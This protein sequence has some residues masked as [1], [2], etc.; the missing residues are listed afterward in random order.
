MRIRGAGIFMAVLAVPQASASSIVTLADSAAWPSVVTL[1]ADNAID[2]S[3]VAATP[4]LDGP[5]PSIVALA[6]TPRDAMPSIIALGEPA[7][8]GEAIAS[9]PSGG[10]QHGLVPIVIRGGEVGDADPR[11]SSSPARAS[12]QQQLD[13][14]DKGTPAK[15]KALKRQ[16]E[17]LA[18]EKAKAAQGSLQPD[19]TT[20][21]PAPGT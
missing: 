19:P 5:S 3:I 16:N 8:A 2:P 20:Q 13:P 6:D 10:S 12:T 15:R 18:Q 1:G 9:P 7:P 11:P 17:R 4:A 14:N 21:A